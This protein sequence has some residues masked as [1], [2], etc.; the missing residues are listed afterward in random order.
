[1]LNN[2]HL[3]SQIRQPDRTYGKGDFNYFQSLYGQA[4]ARMRGMDRELRRS[5][6]AV[7]GGSYDRISRVKT[8]ASWMKERSR[9][10]KGIEERRAESGRVFQIQLA[11]LSA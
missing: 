8:A 9:V 7:T 10:H 4:L 5:A 6:V 3:A 1:M 11:M 2:A